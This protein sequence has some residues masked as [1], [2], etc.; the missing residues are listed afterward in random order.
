MSDPQRV[1]FVCAGN[2]ARSQMAEALRNQRARGRIESERAGSH[3]ADR[4]MEACPILPGH[5]VY[6]HWD[7]E[8]PAEDQGTDED[9]TR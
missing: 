8:D 9:A 7:M 3:P 5:P 2:S 6:A 1:L 4:A